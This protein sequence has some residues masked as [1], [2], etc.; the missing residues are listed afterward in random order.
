[1][2]TLSVLAW[3]PSKKNERRWGDRRSEGRV[4][5]EKTRELDGRLVRAQ[6]GTR[7]TGLSR[8]NRKAIFRDPDS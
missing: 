1:L 4:K 6:E 3:I 2:A 8:V 5:K 7:L